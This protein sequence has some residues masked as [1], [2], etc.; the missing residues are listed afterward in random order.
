M[1]IR[2]IKNYVNGEWVEA[3]NNG[4]LDVENPSTGEVI[5][6]VPLSTISETE[7]T[8][9]AAHEAFKSWRNTPVAH[10]VSYLFKLETEAGM[11]GI[12]TGIPA[13]VAYLP[14]GGMKASLFADIKAQGKEAV[15]FFT[16]ARIVT[17]RYREES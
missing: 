11:I 3:D 15:N 5:S 14:F 2:R 17:E 12:N 16:E 8:L 10:R 4:Y 13:P 1:E 9:K 6:Q 7:R